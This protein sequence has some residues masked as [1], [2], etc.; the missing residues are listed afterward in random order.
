[1]DKAICNV[2]NPLHVKPIELKEPD[3][4]FP[5]RI[6]GIA[7]MHCDQVYRKGAHRMIRHLE[8]EHQLTMKQIIPKWK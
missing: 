8:S 2:F 1:M 4:D 3:P 6:E 5:T 7:C